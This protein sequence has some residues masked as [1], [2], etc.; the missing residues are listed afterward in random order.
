M[1]ICPCSR[2]LGI[3]KNIGIR[4]YLRSVTAESVRLFDHFAFCIKASRHA[5]FLIAPKNCVCWGASFEHIRSVAL[6][7]SIAC[8][9]VC[10]SWGASFEPIT[11]LAP[12][13]T[14]KLQ[15]FH[16][17]PLYH[18]HTLHTLSPTLPHTHLRDSL[19]ITQSCRLM[20]WGCSIGTQWFV[21]PGTSKGFY[22]TLGGLHPKRWQLFTL[23]Y[24][25][26]LIHT[27]HDS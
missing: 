4:T 12:L 8:V 25:A 19:C 1:H 6:L 14:F 18:C 3:C 10:C 11:N 9:A 21:P 20:I 7:H 22:Y 5:T 23:E 16:W 2:A 17:T 26:W 15:A 13:G 27:W 24:V